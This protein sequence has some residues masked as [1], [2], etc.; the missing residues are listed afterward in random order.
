[1]PYGYFERTLL[2]PVQLAPLPPRRPWWVA[3]VALPIVAAFGFA[4]ML[5]AGALPISPPAT[6]TAAALIRSVAPTPLPVR[7]VLP[8]GDSLP[9]EVC[10]Y[11]TNWAPPDP[12]LQAQHLQADV[13]YRNL[14]LARDPRA[15]ERVHVERGPFRSTSGFTDFVELSGLWTDPNASASACPP[16]LQGKAELWGLQLRIQRFE[17]TGSDFVAYADPQ[18]AGVEAVQV[19]VPAAAQALH[20]VDL[21]GV[22]LAPDVNL[23]AA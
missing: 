14:D 15:T 16:D 12:D 5:R 13:R 9:F 20:I 22:K 6:A 4:Y 2:H 18:D 3:L 17:L 7:L 23:R 11:N 10:Y 8:R 21:T 19:A 1:M